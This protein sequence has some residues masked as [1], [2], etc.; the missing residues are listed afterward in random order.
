MVFGA[1]AILDAILDAI[2]VGEIWA[3]VIAVV[4][5]EGRGF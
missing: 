4:G 1:V 5:G 2:L 3:R